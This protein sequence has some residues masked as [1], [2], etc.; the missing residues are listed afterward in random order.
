MI[1]RTYPTKFRDGPL[2]MI[3][4]ILQALASGKSLRRRSARR[5]AAWRPELLESRQLLAATS[6]IIYDIDQSIAGSAFDAPD[7]FVRAGEWVLFTAS[8]S[9]I[10]KELWRTDGTTAGTSLLRDLVP[11]AIGSNPRNLTPLGDSAWFLAYDPWFQERLWRTDGT[12]DGTVPMDMSSIDGFQ[13]LTSLPTTFNSQ[14]FLTVRRRTSTGFHDYLY[15]LDNTGV[16][17]TLVADIP[18][19]NYSF[20]DFAPLT[21]LAVAGD[22]LFVFAQDSTNSKLISVSANGIV[23]TLPSMQGWLTTTDDRA[24]IF[25]SGYDSIQNRF[26]NRLMASD[27]TVSGTL[28]LSL[29]PEFSAGPIENQSITSGS[30]RIWFLQAISDSI[31]LFDKQRMIWTSDGTAEGTKVVAP[32]GGEIAI[33]TAFSGGKFYAMMSDPTDGQNMIWSSDGTESGTRLVQS[34]VGTDGSLSKRL[35]PWKDGVIVRG[36][37]FPMRMFFIDG[38]EQI[39]SSILPDEHESRYVVTS[40]H[41]EDNGLYIGVDDFGE[42]GSKLWFLDAITGAVKKTFSET[43]DFSYPRSWLSDRL[44]G[45]VLFN[46]FLQQQ[47]PQNQLWQ[48]DGT[49]NETSRILFEDGELTERLPRN[50]PAK[51]QADNGVIFLLSNYSDPTELWTVSPASGVTSLV[52]RFE[53]FNFYNRLRYAVAGGRLFFAVLSDGLGQELWVSDGTTAGTFNLKDIVRGAEGVDFLEI[54]SVDSTRVVFAVRNPQGRTELWTSDGTR[55]GTVLVRTFATPQSQSAPFFMERVGTRVLFA[56]DDGVSGREIWVTDGVAANT[57]LLI[58][59]ASGAAGSVSG[60]V[61]NAGTKLY[62]VATSASG[63]EAWWVTDGT[64]AGTRWVMNA[65]L[66]GGYENPA[67]S[68]AVEGKLFVVKTNRRL[69][70]ELIVSHGKAPVSLATF[71]GVNRRLIQEDLFTAFGLLFFGVVD[72]RAGR[73][74][75]YSDGS[76]V[77]LLITDS[78]FVVPQHVSNVGPYRRAWSV[79]RGGLVYAGWDATHG[80]EPA[81]IRTDV[82][83]RSPGGI[84]W[85]TDA[86]GDYVSWNESFG[87][88]HYEVEIRDLSV[89]PSDVTLLS[90]AGSLFR[91]PAAFHDRALEIRVRGL[92]SA[93]EPGDWSVPSTSV[94]ADHPVLRPLPAQSPDASPTIQW[95][96]PQGFDAVEIWVSDL[97]ARRRIFHIDSVSNSPSSIT[98]PKLAPA[99]YAVFVR[100]IRN[101]GTRSEWSESLTFD[102]PAAPPQILTLSQPAETLRANI[103]WNTVQKATE[104]EIEIRQTGSVSPSRLVSTTRLPVTETYFGLRPGKFTFR[105][106]AVRSGRVISDWSNPAELLVRSAPVIRADSVQVSWSPIAEA[107]GYEFRLV[108]SGSGAEVFRRTVTNTNQLFDPGFA[109]GKYRAEVQTKY[110]DGTTSSVSF[111]AFERFATSVLILSGTGT[112]LDATPVIGWKAQTGV[113]QYELV[114]YRNNSKIPAYRVITGTVTSHRI[115]TPL[116]NGEFTVWVRAHYEFDGKSAWGSGGRLSIGQRPVVT[117]NGLEIHWTESAGAT[118]YELW[119]NL[120]NPVTGRQTAVVRTSQIFEPR[121]TLSGLSAGTYRGW[122]RGIRDEAGAAYKSEWS[123]GFNVLVN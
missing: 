78:S 94:T 81:I 14:M 121:L 119:L 27:G 67:Q 123:L 99:R 55:A 48:S 101:D 47:S 34:G 6:S 35:L 92:T 113:I 76:E 105:V 66:A 70:Q 7:S 83:H 96:S 13:R 107:V 95:A 37:R 57:K 91:L 112:T 88:D 16:T 68:V 82:V 10:G 74:L 87:A 43:T 28:E 114:V 22:H 36:S 104:Y 46:T 109:P 30:D 69:E 31:Y 3:F 2:T 25:N 9:E 59:I 26:V 106:R 71:D 42:G 44:S 11:G 79:L 100:G 50:S 4:E 80:V 115:A 60:T 21:M 117:S 24:M 97:D 1:T 12:P 58:N 17:P 38:T 86:T 89:L 84:Q 111:L 116:S 19:G 77:H 53:G 73:Q 61:R 90:S 39:P 23:E 118:R 18:L 93:D 20:G 8:N 75:W 40:V 33:D 102:V 63:Q 54:A 41:V 120:V 49:A 72:A 64:N 29:G 98:L 110:A 45:R 103:S 62:F 65:V 52:K 51:I 56:A 108:Q 85:L 122:I 5:R 15:A 32:I